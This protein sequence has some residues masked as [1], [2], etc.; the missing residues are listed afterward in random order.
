MVLKF[1]YTKTIFSTI[2]LILVLPI[3]ISAQKLY[4]NEF[5]ASNVT[6][7]PE[8]LDFDDYSDWIEIYNDENQPI[9]LSGYYI[10]DNL[11]NPRKHQIR[12]GTIIEAK[13][14]LLLWADGMRDEDNTS[15]TVNHHLNFKLSMGGEEIGLF[16]PQGA[17]IDSIVFG[18]QITDVSFGRRPDSISVWNYFGEPTPAQA[19]NTIGTLN[20]E[21]A[22][23]PIFSKQGGVYNSFTK[24]ALSVNSPTAQ[25]RFTMD[26]SRPTRTSIQYTSVI[27]LESTT[28]LRAR[29]FDGDLLPG[30]IITHSYLINETQTLPIISITAFPETMFDNEI[31][32]YANSIKGREIPVSL[33]YFKAGGELGFALNSGLRISG[34]LIIPKNQ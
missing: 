19:N 27:N 14:Y 34:H 26:G 21:K 33:E 1:T 31:G 10:T 8:I 32:I 30:N 16:N 7:N 24:I 29:V 5:L 20:T 12:S 28:V 22:D 18:L 4:I 13:G 2:I 23:E 3:L 11:G 6:T 25:I 17:L 15:S 9:D